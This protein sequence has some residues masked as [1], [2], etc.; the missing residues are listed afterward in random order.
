MHACTKDVQAKDISSSSGTLDSFSFS[1]LLFLYQRDSK[2]GVRSSKKRR[3]AKLST[4]AA[5]HRAL[6]TAWDEDNCPLQ[7]LLKS[8]RSLATFC[9]ITAS[10]KRIGD[11][12]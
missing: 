12:F 8:T 6:Q 4:A 11:G 3:K 10:T 2:A 7:M 9:P 1:L 5:K